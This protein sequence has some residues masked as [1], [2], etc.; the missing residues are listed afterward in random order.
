M[1]S[2]L[3][4]HG[5]GDLDDPTILDQLAFFIRDHEKFKNMLM[6]VTPEERAN[7]Y[8]AI[9]P[10]ITFFKP[11]TL[12]QYEAEGKREAENLPVFDPVT[13]AVTES[14]GANISEEA[15]Q[16]IR[17][18]SCPHCDAG[19]AMTTGAPIG[20]HFWGTDKQIA[21]P[22]SVAR[23]EREIAKLAEK[24]QDAIAE[25][26]GKSTARGRLEIVC[27]KCQFG[28]TVYATDRLDAY[29]TLL[30]EGWNVSGDHAYCPYCKPLV[31]DSH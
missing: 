12:E 31:I 29:A 25:D 11:K 4:K 28:V 13:W 3:R 18:E 8:K 1:N 6:K 14:K 21:C 24:A 16:A 20:Y 2:H 23:H 19:E 15:K 26:W 27:R 9:A 22:L 5:L 7:A 17:G 10:R 30:A